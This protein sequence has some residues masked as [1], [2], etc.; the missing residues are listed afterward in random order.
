MAK[1]VLQKRK[2]LIY[3][4][5]HAL[6]SGSMNSFLSDFQQE[7]PG[8]TILA[9]VSVDGS[10]A[11]VFKRLLDHCKFNAGW[12]DHFSDV[13]EVHFDNLL[14]VWPKL[15]L[16]FQAYREAVEAA[17]A[18]AASPATA[19]LLTNATAEL[20]RCKPRQCVKLQELLAGFPNLEASSL[21]IA[22]R[23]ALQAFFGEGLIRA[24]YDALLSAEAPIRDGQDLLARVK[25]HNIFLD[26]ALL[27][28][29]EQALR[30]PSVSE[31]DQS[32]ISSLLVMMLPPRNGD[33]K[34]DCKAYFFR[35]YFCPDE[36]ST[37]DQWQRMD[38]KSVAPSIRRQCWEA[39]LQGLI[40]EAI[41]RAK[42][43]M[44]TGAEKLLIEIFLPLRSL[45]SAIGS[46]LEIPRPMGG[47]KALGREYPLVI[48]SS[49]RFQHFHEAANE[50][51]DENRLPAKWNEFV[52]S[53][54]SFW[55]HDV[56]NPSPQPS[57]EVEKR[58]RDSFDAFAVKPE[59][60]AMKR[61]GKLP[62]HAGAWLEAML[63]ACPAVAIW[64]PLT[65]TS[66][67]R[68][69]RQCFEF[70]WDE[71]QTSPFGSADPTKTVPHP[72]EHFRHP[73]DNSLRLFYALAHTVQRG[74]F[75][76]ACGKPFQEMLLLVDAPDRWPV[77]LDS[78]PGVLTSSAEDG[79]VFEALEDDVLISPG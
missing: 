57:L 79:P 72:T 11:D 29:L 37:P 26:D 50:F 40:C 32:T 46:K 22:V 38:E 51:P 19:P 76:K 12:L 5:V 43:Q 1:V 74:Q 31:Q 2:D 28:E 36:R 70:H 66:T 39:D 47:S 78:V 49:E 4:L 7:E 65:A 63:W 58:I 13:M 34:E 68:Q 18:P 35:A 17:N 27:A 14:S 3:L 75:E 42:K 21:Q 52:S 64:W 61:L 23:Q 6:G 77:P 33:N 45:H 15:Q 20:E 60:F 16:S 10:P 62:E 67:S 73:Y 30:N 69:R 54:N 55:W 9:N 59:W 8:L 48:R 53:S 24:P 56:T 44:K 71:S 25:Q 41:R